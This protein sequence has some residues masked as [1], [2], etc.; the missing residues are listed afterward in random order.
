MTLLLLLSNVIPTGS[1]VLFTTIASEPKLI[2]VPETVP[3]LA[4]VLTPPSL[5]LYASTTLL[6]LL[7]NVR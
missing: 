5:N 2:L 4:L 6:L 7:S 1:E 3:T